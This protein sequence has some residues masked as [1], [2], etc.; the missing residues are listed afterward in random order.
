MVTNLRLERAFPVRPPS[1]CKPCGARLTV[2]GAPTS[3]TKFKQAKA[4]QPDGCDPQQWR[5]I[6]CPL[7]C[8]QGA[9][10]ARCLIRIVLQ[11]S[12]SQKRIDKDQHATAGRKAC[13]PKHHD[14]FFLILRLP[15]VVAKLSMPTAPVLTT[16]ET[17]SRNPNTTTKPVSR[18]AAAGNRKREFHQKT[19]SPG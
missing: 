12:L 5:A 4:C 13:P 7:Q 14:P 19:Q 1:S 11:S 10:Y 2:G 18:G 17:I 9:R 8:S 3:L 6:R 16:S 15:E